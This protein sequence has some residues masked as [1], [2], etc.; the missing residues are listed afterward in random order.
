MSPRFSPSNSRRALILITTLAVNATSIAAAVATPPNTSAN[1]TIEPQSLATALQA[2]SVQSGLQV[3]FESQL[4][5][6]IQSQGTKGV[7]SATEA[8]GRLLKGTGLEYHFVNDQ[9]VVVREKA[10]P[11]TSA[12]S[13]N[14]REM[15]LAR[16]DI[17]QGMAG[18]AMRDGHPDSADSSRHAGDTERQTLEEIMVVGSRFQKASALDSPSP[19]DVY[20]G[21]ELRARGF[22]DLSKML[23]FLAPAL[24]FARSTTAPSSANNRGV[25]LRGLG[26][27][28]VLVM[29]NGKR[30][31]ASSVLNFNAGIGRG[32]VPTDLNTIPAMAIKRIEILRDGAAAQYGSD[33]IAGVINIVLQDSPEGGEA[34]LMTGIT[35]R[36]DGETAVL[37]AR[38]G[39]PLANGGFVSLAGED[40]FRNATNS[41]IV[42]PRVGFVSQRTGDPK[43]YDLNLTANAEAPFAAATPYGF[44]TFSRRDSYSVPLFRLPSVAPVLYPNG[45]LP[46]V[47]LDMLDFGGSLGVKGDLGSFAWD[48]SDTGGYDRANFDV[49]NTANTSLG[50]ASPTSFDGGGV[51]YAQNLLN[52][53]F[54]RSFDVLAGLHVAAGLEHRYE[55]Y[56][57]RAGEPLSYAGTGAQGFPGFHPPTPVDT[58]RTARSAFLDTEISLVQ[59]LNLGLA[60]RH[61][62]Y[63]DFGGRTTGKASILWQAL[64]VLALR[65]TASTGFRAPSLQQQYFST[66]TSQSS[67]ASLVNVGTFAVN[68]PVA[69]ALGA[70]PLKAE[71][72]TNY[73]VG[74]IVSPTPH[75]TFTADAYHISVKDRI[76]LSESLTGNAV[77]AI[78]VS[79]GIVN[80]SQVRFFTNAAD[81][82][83]KGLEATVGW[84]TPVRD[85][86]N[87]SVNLAYGLF[88]NSIATLRAN[89]V[90][91]ALPLL[92]PASI[93]ILTAAEPHDKITLNSALELG[94]M[95]LVGDIVRFGRNSA[96]PNATVQVFSPK[97]T[98]DLSASFA[99]SKQFHIQAGVINLTDTFPDKVSGT[100]GNYVGDGRPYAEVGAIGTD[101]REYFAR[102]SWAF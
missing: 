6:G 62:H 59:G 24:N 19:V 85:R 34:S 7:G 28:Q 76:A 89:P 23:Q 22:N 27:D 18:E 99:M 9:T 33:A 91:P 36:G 5:K 64:P 65:S 31:H 26:Q 39:L 73:S 54:T 30:R 68:D 53:T 93:A 37:A 43:S 56:K 72:S 20:S 58:H 90:L 42:D 4:A 84:S 86:G 57:I 82:V 3:G 78:L 52:L 61:E 49:S 74:V 14:S 21:T 13:M 66:I 94:R 75:F 87:L 2:F 16:A 102:L 100:T 29:V 83:S 15:R 8:L 17:G 79:H 46:Q 12:G 50:A 60:A 69:I 88:D 80:A 35:E 97:V 1:I 63:S 95:T 25:S 45:F 70:T 101:G 44:G 81:T 41:A 98:V 51:R 10:S 71:H 11:S 38:R 32:T 55:A 96:I 40:R 48:L 77:T 47:K 92:A 67:G